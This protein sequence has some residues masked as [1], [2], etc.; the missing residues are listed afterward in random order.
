MNINGNYGG[1]GSEYE[2]YCYDNGQDQRNSGNGNYGDGIIEIPVI[3][4]SDSLT[5]TLEPLQRE[6][7]RVFGAN[8]FQVVDRCLKAG[9]KSFHATL[10]TIN[11]STREQIQDIN[12]AI[13]GAKEIMGNTPLEMVIEGPVRYY[14]T[15]EP[16]GKKY[17]GLN[18]TVNDPRIHRFTNVISEN[19]PQPCRDSRYH[20]NTEFH[21]TLGHIQIQNVEQAE[22]LER[23]LEAIPPAESYTHA[24]TMVYRRFTGVLHP[25]VFR[26]S[27]P[28]AEVEAERIA[29]LE[30]PTPNPVDDESWPIANPGAYYP[31]EESV[32]ADVPE[33]WDIG[34]SDDEG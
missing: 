28:F 9:H 19:L 26:W 1:Y 25:R 5:R 18:V 8:A 23:I 10:I 33:R 21:V 34:L 17:L 30:L 31:D 14:G 20:R 11:N 6:I 24:A 32:E 3:D 29:A 7:D 2:D 22:A 13:T 16:V 27:R 12:N 15:R 4:Y